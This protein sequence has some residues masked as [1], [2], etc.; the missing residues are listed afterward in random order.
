[1]PNT[2]DTYR[3]WAQANLGNEVAIDKASTLGQASTRVSALARFFG[4][5][6]ATE[7]RKDAMSDFTRALSVEFGTGIAQKALEKYRLS[8]SSKLTGSTIR[9]VI[10]R[11]ESLRNHAQSNLID[12]LRLVNGETVRSTINRL[13]AQTDTQRCMNRYMQYR[14]VA[15]E[16]LGEMPLDQPSYEDFSLRVSEVRAKLAKLAELR[17]FD[18]LDPAIHAELDRIGHA[19]L[20]K[21]LQSETMIHDAPLSEGND[22]HFQTVWC[23]AALNGLQT[24]RGK[25][26]NPAMQVKLD[27]MI[28]AFGNPDYVKQFVKDIPIKKEVDKHL[29]SVL[30]KE[31]KSQVGFFKREFSEK[32]LASAIALGYR[33]ALNM[34]D[35]PI[36]SKT[37]DAAIGSRPVKLRSEICSAE[38]L[39]ATQ[40]Q[41]RGPIGDTY[42]PDVHGFMCHTANTPH[43]VNLAVSSLSVEDAAGQPQLAFRGVRHG[44]HS[45]WEIQDPT[46]RTRS[47]VQRARETVMAAWLAAHPNPPNGPV[48]EDINLTSVSLLSPDF[49]RNTKKY[50]TKD[51]ERRMLEEQTKAWE[52]VQQFGVTFTYGGQTITLRPQIL[53]FNFGV[54]AGAVRYSGPI[55]LA[56]GWE[57][58][59]PMNKKAFAALDAAVQ[60]FVNTPSADP[61]VLHRQKYVRILLA[62]LKDILDKGDESSD[63]NDAYKAAARVSVLTHLLGWTPCWNCKSGKDRTGEMDVECKFLATLIAKD[64]AIP[65]PGMKLNAEQQGLFRAIAFEGGNFEVQ[66]LNTGFAGYKTEHVHSIPERLGG[67]DYRTFH[68]GGSSNV[69]V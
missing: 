57:V 53:T 2:I 33:K 48:S 32:Q 40:G 28:D 42:P 65:L 27:A 10:A 14:S 22:K 29:A 31:I 6:A 67:A 8:E 58:S 39:G 3:Q 1:M 26:T 55:G 38:K 4:T 43:A 37:F 61:A 15:V 18:R 51:D 30:M 5:S 52:L 16:L 12:N 63:H 7:L 9:A 60:T 11:A 41:A 54:N 44:V 23:Q 13:A 21:L 59:R 62:Q 34:Q 66:K 46:L 45:A 35:W 68:K 17:G 69:G 19:L 25:V 49:Y 56:G 24:L 20:D 50:G 47:N 64:L 36:I